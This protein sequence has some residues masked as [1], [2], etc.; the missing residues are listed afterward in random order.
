[1]KDH[2]K[3]LLGLMGFEKESLDG[4][5]FNFKEQDSIEY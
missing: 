3:K 5:A 1:M 4:E 2:N